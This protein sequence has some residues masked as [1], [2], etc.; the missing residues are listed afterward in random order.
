MPQPP[1]DAPQAVLA[2]KDCVQPACGVSQTMYLPGAR[3]RVYVPPE[4]VVVVAATVV[5]PASFVPFPF[6]STYAVMPQPVRPGSPASRTPFAFRSS[7][8]TP[9]FVAC[10]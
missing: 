10:W 4:P 1:F 3:L 7:N 9:V 2:G 5:S 6:T 8:L